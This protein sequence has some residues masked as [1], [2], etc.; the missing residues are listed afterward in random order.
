MAR[1]KGL[2]D[3]HRAFLVRELA[4]FATPKQAAEALKAE[5]GIEVSP[6]ATERY[7]PGKS[8]GKKLPAKWREL[9]EKARKAFLEH[10]E[11]SVPNANKAVRV[12]KLSRAA[13]SF[14]RR[15]NYVAMKEM[16][17]AVAKEMGNVHTNRRELTGKDG[18]PVEIVNLTE[19]QINRQLAML[20]ADMPNDEGMTHDDGGY[21]VH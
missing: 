15:G 9:F 16:L 6:Q 4:C 21:P 17:E 7:D 2:Q 20:L 12:A 11:N 5:F 14:E 18:K 8:A 10:V 19:E 3:V 13:D 1:G